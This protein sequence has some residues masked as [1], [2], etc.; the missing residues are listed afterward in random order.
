MFTAG[1]GR[2]ALGVVAVGA[3]VALAGCA[4]GDPLD[5]GSSSDSASS[6][7]I[8]IGSQDYYSNEIIAEIYAQALEAND[9][10]V[11][12]DFRIGQRE[13]YL[14]EVESGSI[15]LFP[16]Y[17]GN[18]LQFYDESTTARTSDD[19][20]AALQG[21]LPD[22]L[23]VLDQSPATD[24]DSYNVTRTFSEANNVTSLADLASV[25]TPLTLGG[26]SELETRP[27]GPTGLKDVYGAT[28]GFT[29]IEDSG[30][31]LTLKALVDDQVQL[32]N[33]YSADPNIK[34]ND[35]VTLADPKGLF[36]ASN[37][38]PLASDKVTDDIA[39][40]I[41]TVSAAMTPEDLVSMNAQSVND[42]ESADVIAK[43]WLD[44]KALF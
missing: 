34:A 22:G 43:N 23:R 4:S 44:E 29:P 16:E 27:Y 20:F 33:I 40:I 18:L 2:L 1:K 30:G 11:Q 19:V 17:T 5:G 26:N 8:V 21:V 3:A 39:A 24:Q 14:P 31:P 37:V 7:T 10:D 6:E 15:D 9:I 35:L 12:R 36:L 42:Q 38:V 28:V 25:T 13:V 32:V 41:N